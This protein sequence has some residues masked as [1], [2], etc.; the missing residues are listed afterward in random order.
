MR[1]LLS[2]ALIVATLLPTSAFALEGRGPRVT[3]TGIVQEVSITEK[4]KFDKEGGQFVIRASNG[5]LVTIILGTEADYEI[6]SEGRLSRKYLIPSD[7]TVGM[8]VRV[9]GWRVNSNTLNASLFVITNIELNPQ[10]TTSG[11]LQEIGTNT[12]TLLLTNGE[13][14]TYEVTN[15]TQ[16]QLNYTLFGPSALNPLGKLAFLTL[17]PYNANQVRIIRITGES[18]PTRTTKPSTVELRRR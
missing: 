7:V 3:V 4:Q 13:S 2:S 14:K 10:L 8:S 16:I 15:D 17:S 11:T 9:R 18:D 1:A 6:I 12:I 5:Q